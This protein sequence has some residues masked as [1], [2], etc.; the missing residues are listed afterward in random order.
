M[1]RMSK[2]V[3]NVEFDSNKG[4]LG[5]TLLT[6]NSVKSVEV[7]FIC[8]FKLAFLQIQKLIISTHNF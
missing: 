6:T 7:R 8:G 2:I 4:S 1:R 3:Y 5:Y